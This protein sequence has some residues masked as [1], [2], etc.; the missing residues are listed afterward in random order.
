MSK[1]LITGATGFIGSHVAE[2]FCEKGIDVGCLVRRESGLLNIEGLPVRLESGDLRDSVSLTKALKGYD[3][4]IHIAAKASD[5]GAYETFYQTN[6][7]GTLN[8]LRAC[9]ENKI[10]HVIMTSSISVYGEE[11]CTQVKNENSP[12]KSHY[13]YFCDKLFPCK[14]NYYRDTKGLAKEKAIEFAEKWGLNLTILE[15]VWVYGEREFNTGFFEYLKTAQGGIPFLPGSKQNKFHVIYV[16]DLARAFYLAYLKKLP[17]VES[18]IIGNKETEKMDR[19]Y[20]LF[21]EKARVK[22]P[23]NI[24][25]Y[26]FYPL[27]F[28]WELCCTVLNTRNA[29]LL[30]R[31]RVN[32]FYD[33]IEYSIEKAEKLLG[34]V[35]EYSIAEGIERTVK[36]YQGQNLI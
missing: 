14:M 27:G 10:S 33:N 3:S 30:T 12:G 8:V 25:K 5:W 22:K 18:V 7:E 6:V 17:G 28:F 24:P 36:W 13:Q 21:C 4:V 35:N 2:T 19:I 11:N 9:V 16:K 26:V 23:V 15:P 1:V 32:M 31:G 29:P 34:F 20:S